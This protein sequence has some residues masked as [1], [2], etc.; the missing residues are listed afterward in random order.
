MVWIERNTSYNAS[1]KVGEIYDTSD[2]TV[3]YRLSVWRKIFI[4][5]IHEITAVMTLKTYFMKIHKMTFIMTLIGAT[6][7]IVVSALI[8]SSSPRPE[9]TSVPTSDSPSTSTTPPIGKDVDS[10]TRK[11]N[12]DQ[13]DNRL[14]CRQ[15][16]L[17]AASLVEA[18]LEG[19]DMSAAQLWNADL[20]GAR[21]TNANLTGTDLES[22][23]LKDANLVGANL[24][25]AKLFSANLSGADLSGASLIGAD[26]FNADL[27]GV[28]GA[29]FTGALNVANKYLSGEEISE[30]FEFVPVIP[31]TKD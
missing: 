10:F 16:D 29:D 23:L 12:L 5:K 8:I 15:C 17:T 4:M 19:A 6:V 20:S 22:A 14:S 13:R 7:L 11:L 31:N 21:L 27:E 30:Q 28:I 2:G 25:G 24:S 1:E 9:A 26:F 3:F 18:D